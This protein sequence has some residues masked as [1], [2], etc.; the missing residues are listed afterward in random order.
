MCLII[1]D[2]NVLR[3]YSSFFRPGL[4]THSFALRCVP[5]ASVPCSNLG[6]FSKERG[7]GISKLFFLIS[8]QRIKISLEFVLQ[9]I[10]LFILLLQLNHGVKG[11]Q[12]D[13]FIKMFVD[14][15]NTAK[16]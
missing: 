2:E 5:M 7:H 6:S 1:Q 3:T 8:A 9:N 12:C 16:N 13:I 15:M 4:W 11:R 10:F 14:K